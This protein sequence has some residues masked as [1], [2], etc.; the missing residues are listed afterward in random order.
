MTLFLVLV[1]VGLGSYFGAHALSLR[2]ESDTRC[3]GTRCDAVGL[4][5][6][7]DARTDAHASTIAFAIAGA[8]L[9]TGTGL[10]IWVATDGSSSANA[11][12]A[13]RF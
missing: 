10:L 8:A 2:D 11:V 3:D 6:Y 7:G 13:G 9:A 4:D 12:V 5:L 1:G